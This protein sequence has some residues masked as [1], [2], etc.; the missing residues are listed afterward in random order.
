MRHTSA[1]ALAGFLITISTAHS[2]QP[3][4]IGTGTING[5]VSVWMEPGAVSDFGVID[6]H[7][8]FVGGR[9]DHD[10]PS[11]GFAGDLWARDDKGLIFLDSF[12]CALGSVVKNQYVV[13]ALISCNNAPP[14]PAAG[15]LLPLEADAHVVLEAQFAT[16]HGKVEIRPSGPPPTRRK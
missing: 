8:I 12:S 14:Q 13:Y 1:I 11:I 16:G 4:P 2:E 6:L 3:P 7:K 9:V 10:S 15:K 5:E